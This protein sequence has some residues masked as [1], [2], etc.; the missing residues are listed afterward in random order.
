MNFTEYVD[1]LRARFAG[2]D[3]RRVGGGF[4]KTGG[5]VV[6]VLKES[7]EVR[8]ATISIGGPRVT[9]DVGAPKIDDAPTAFVFAAVDDWIAF[10]ERADADR[11]S[12]I[13][14]F[15][16]AAVLGLLPELAAQAQ[17]PLHARL[18]NFT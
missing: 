11:V 5:R 10:F 9:V 14:F 7:G 3:P 12:S 8:R 13:D 17:S 6:L 4:G 16:D 1:A 18:A 2:K 15:G